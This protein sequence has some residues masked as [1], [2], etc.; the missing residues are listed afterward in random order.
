MFHSVLKKLVGKT[1]AD[2]EKMEETILAKIKKRNLSRGWVRESG[3]RTAP[4]K[5]LYAWII[6]MGKNKKQENVSDPDVLKVR[7]T[8]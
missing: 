8:H 1:E 7:F 3:K 4:M 5:L 6:K 2:V